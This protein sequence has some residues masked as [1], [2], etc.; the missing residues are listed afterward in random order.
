[1]W[2]SH[3]SFAPRL[4]LRS[5]TMFKDSG[6]MTTKNEQVIS[7]RLTNYHQ[8][9]LDLL[10]S[11]LPL[12]EALSQLIGVIEQEANGM[13]G[14]VLL[15]SSD[16]MHLREGAS[17]NLPDF[18]RAAIDGVA[19]GEAVGSCGTAAF[20]GARVIVEDINSH[21]YWVEFK[22][23]ALQAN[24]QACWSQPILQKGTVLGT[25]ALYYSKP[26]IPDQ[27]HISLI[28]DAAALAKV[29]I[30]KE[31]S[32]ELIKEKERALVEAEKTAQWK[33]NFFANM[34]HEIR[35]PLNGIV[36]IV[37]LMA[38]TKSQ[39]DQAKYVKTLNASTTTLLTVINDIL[40][41][42]KLNE[43]MLALENIVFNTQEFVDS[44]L[45][46]HQ[47][48]G[49]RDIKVVRQV[50]ASVPTWVEG[51]PV[52]LQQ[53]VGNLL[54]NAFKFTSE[55]RVELCVDCTAREADTVTLL[56]KVKDT[57]VGIARGQLERIF[58]QYEQADYSTCRQF[59]GSGLGL[60]ICKSLAG[61]FGGDVW[62]ESEPGVGSVFHVQVPLKVRNEPIAAVE[63]PGSQV[64]FSGLN[65]LLV[66]DNDVNVMVISKHLQ[67]MNIDFTIAN[68][69]QEGV[70][71]YSDTEAPFDLVL[72][73]CEM[74]IMDG[75][76][77]THRIREW[78][79]Q[80]HS[81]RV[82]I[83]ALT[84]HAMDEHVE[85]CLAAG[86]DYH[87]AKPVT[88]AAIEDAFGKILAD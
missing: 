69:G 74:P 75:Y 13:L 28:E 60:Y 16:K 87:L 58:G 10:V 39:S 33:S 77:A 44:L 62:A 41:V 56:F 31:L 80:H 64:D 49:R 78:E 7:A 6:P 72:M 84:A 8:S 29:L 83:C 47:L 48:Q 51:D 21:P 82:P 19:I 15:M 26:Q 37:E 43:G 73:D 23:V 9:L 59:G 36:G 53:I 57:G 32:K 88:R 18:Y 55:G 50:D 17:P 25:F 14:S 3:R 45:M 66:E 67:K 40:D 24:L 79:A 86:M 42:S 52:R 22:G 46:V 65:L 68:N 71:A 61:L 5:I 30:E 34:S 70:N 81:N 38:D 63:D 4:T 85:K 1:M 76:Q 2:Q 20:T 54:N 11:D 12:K 35:T 27:D